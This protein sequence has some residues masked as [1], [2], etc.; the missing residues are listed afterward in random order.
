MPQ[1]RDVVTNI[2]GFNRF[3]T[4]VLGL[5]DRHILHS[6]Y[7][8][9]EARVLFEIAKTDQCVANQL[10]STLAIDRSYMS[11]IIAKFEKQGLLTR[12][13]RDTDSRFIDI[14][15]TEE[16]IRLF[17]ELNGRSNQQIEELLS[18]VGEEGSQKICEAMKTIRKYLTIATTNLSIRPF[19]ADDVKYVIDRQLS[20]YETERQFTS[21]VWKQYVTQAVLALVEQFDPERDCMYILECN[22][23]RAGC[24]AIAHT[25][26]HAAQLRFFFLEPELRGLGAGQ[27]LLNAALDFC[28]DKKYHHVFLWTVSAQESA[29][30]LYSRAGFRI[31][32]TNDN[33]EWGVPVTEERWDLAL[34][35]EAAEQ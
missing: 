24:V 33:A 11:R 9:T 32:E 1:D 28:R 20:L 31:T 18:K 14:R 26:S 23:N 30:R 22:G 16:G 6:G 35:M 7:S 21:D 5:L 4:N 29:R 15:L 3:Y 34:D 17:H 12:V 25:E 13:V 10:A 19:N 27:R 8:L 2:R